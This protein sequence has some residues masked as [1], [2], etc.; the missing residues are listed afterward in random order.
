LG[1]I[2]TNPIVGLK[3]AIYKCNP[4]SGFVHIWPKIGLKQ[5]SIFWKCI[6]VF[7]HTC[8]GC[9]TGTV[10]APDTLKKIHI[11]IK[12]TICKDQCKGQCQATKLYRAWTTRFRSRF[13]TS[14][15]YSWCILD[16]TKM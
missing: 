4:T 5:P 14:I 15:L 3:N 2:W 16:T 1:Q 11:H 8:W 9:W 13:N 7:P 6:C 10:L 12:A